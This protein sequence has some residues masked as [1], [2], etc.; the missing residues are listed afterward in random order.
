MEIV[1]MRIVQNQSISIVRHLIV[2]ILF[3]FNEGTQFIIKETKTFKGW[4]CL[5]ESILNFKKT[6]PPLVSL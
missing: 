1:L 6:N 2:S 3:F 4:I 5:L